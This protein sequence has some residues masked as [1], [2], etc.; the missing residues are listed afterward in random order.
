M[1]IIVAGGSQQADQVTSCRFA[2]CAESI[3]VDI[4]LIGVGSQPFD[5]RFAVVN[6]S[7]KNRVLAKAVI[8]A[9]YSKTG[10]NEFADRC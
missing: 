1:L 6:L 9:C 8:E 5:G 2:K 7:W 10:L 4:V 3:G